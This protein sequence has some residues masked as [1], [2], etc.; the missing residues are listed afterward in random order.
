MVRSMIGA[1]DPGA[2]VSMP[3][4]PSRSTTLAAP[5]PVVV[6]TATRGTRAMR[7]GLRPTSSGAISTSVS[8]M[9]TRTMPLARKNASIAASLPAMA[10]V[11]ERASAWPSAERPSL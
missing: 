1:S 2:T 5:P 10:P 11:C 9:S 6:T 4:M 3:C 8:S 7:G